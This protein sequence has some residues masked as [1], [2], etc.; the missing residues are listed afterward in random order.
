MSCQK[1]ANNNQPL[2]ISFWWSSAI[3]IKL[4]LTNDYRQRCA[5]SYWL[6]AELE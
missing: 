6:T 5:E 4:A 3:T 2:T 1:L